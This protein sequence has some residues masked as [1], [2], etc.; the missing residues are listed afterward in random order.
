MLIPSQSTPVMSV[1][2]NHS[3]EGNKCVHQSIH[4]NVQ[5]R[6]TGCHQSPA[7]W[8]TDTPASLHA[9]TQLTAHPPTH[10]GKHLISTVACRLFPQLEA[11][12]PFSAPVDRPGVGM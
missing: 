4:R 7:Q 9:V 10:T 1:S 3:K 12:T 11:G 8:S 2:E 6:A 5:T